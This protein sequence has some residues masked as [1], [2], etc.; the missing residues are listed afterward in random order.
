MKQNLPKL[1]NSNASNYSAENCQ[2]QN[3]I[4]H[5]MHHVIRYVKFS[6]DWKQLEKFLRFWITSINK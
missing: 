2:N 3:C 6:S 5:K 4:K 1:T